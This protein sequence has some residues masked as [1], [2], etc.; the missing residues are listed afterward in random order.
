MRFLAL[1]SA[2]LVKL[3]GPLESEYRIVLKCTCSC[4][5]PVEIHA[6]T[7]DFQLA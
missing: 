4:A 7:V 1:K 6:T 3:S 2:R 5:H